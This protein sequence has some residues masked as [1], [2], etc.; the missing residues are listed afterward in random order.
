MGGGNSNIINADFFS[1]LKPYKKYPTKKPQWQL[2]MR[3]PFKCQN[4]A[5][6][7]IFTEHVLEHFYI[8]D[9]HKLLQECLRILK[10]NGILRISVPDLQQHIQTYCELKNTKEA[11]RAA[12]VIRNLTQEYLHLSV[13]D[14]DRLEYELQCIGFSHIQKRSY[15][16]GNDKSLLF[17]LECR[18]KGSLYVEARK[19]ESNI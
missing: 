4:N 16:Q 3:Y 15:L 5:F 10:P 11:Y 14:Y 2:D 12:E 17:D 1:H 7:G 9:A 19:P 8:D 6:D 18:S 13:W